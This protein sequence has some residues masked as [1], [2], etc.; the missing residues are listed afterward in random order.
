MKVYVVLDDG[1]SCYDAGGIFVDVFQTL[2]E[3]EAYLS[4]Y[5]SNYGRYDQDFSI[6]EVEI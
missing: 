4:K 6:E 2:E 5:L 1:K 3:A